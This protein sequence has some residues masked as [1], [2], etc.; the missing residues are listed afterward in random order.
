MGSSLK[1]DF[2]ADAFSQMRI[3]GL[4]IDPTPSDL[5]LA[6]MRLETM[7]AEW[8]R[9]N[10]CAGY[11]F[12]DSPDPNTETLVD[13]A[14]WHAFATNLAIRL[15][16]DFNKQVP[17]V[18]MQQASQSLSFISTQTALDRLN[19]VDAPVRMPLGSGNTFRYNRWWRYYRK[20]NTAPNS[21]E[22]KILVV[23]N[24]EDY[25]ES[26]AAYLVDNE[27]IDTY[28][29][30][31]D[32]KL[33]IVSESNTDEDV[34]FRI[35]ASTGSSSDN[36]IGKQQLTISIKTDTGRVHTRFIFFDIKADPLNSTAGL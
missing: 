20:A 9:R 18:L 24:I 29:I 36:D 26:F 33:E 34:S 13:L 27:V 12:E 32:P 17:Q 16:P 10:I 28:D 11:N 5:E 3:S 25:T 21:C 1:V 35:K 4:T 30:V 15:I 7:A 31:T 19:Q 14:Y 6:L 23:G 22:T 8:S 2:V